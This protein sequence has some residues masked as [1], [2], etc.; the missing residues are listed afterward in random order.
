MSQM[1]GVN[2]ITPGNPQLAAMAP[3]AGAIARAGR[4]GGSFVGGQ[5]GGPDRELMKEQLKAQKAMQKMELQLSSNAQTAQNRQQTF[6]QQAAAAFEADQVRQGYDFMAMARQQMSVQAKAEKDLLRSTLV[7]HIRD[8]ALVEDKDRMGTLVYEIHQAFG[9]HLAQEEEVYSRSRNTAMQGILNALRTSQEVSTRPE[10]PL[11]NTWIGGGKW[12]GDAAGAAAGA[13]GLTDNA[14]DLSSMAESVSAAWSEGRENASSINTATQAMVTHLSAA[15]SSKGDTKEA[16]LR[17]AAAQVVQLKE[18]GVTEVE[19]DGL[20]DAL[21]TAGSNYKNA[22]SEN[23]NEAEGA[24]AASGQDVGDLSALDGLSGKEVQQ[25]GAMAALSRRLKDYDKR[26]EVRTNP[27]SAVEDYG[28]GQLTDILAEW[29]MGEGTSEQVKEMMK[30]L[31]QDLQEEIFER[32]ESLRR[33][34]AVKARTASRAAGIGLDQVEEI[35]AESIAEIAEYDPETAAALQ[36]AAE[37]LLD[38]ERQG[39]TAQ[40]DAQV[41]YAN[42]LAE[43]VANIDLDLSNFQQQ[44]VDDG[45][46]DIL[47]DLR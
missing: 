36:E 46:D 8:E 1:P 47:E 42:T 7:A 25:L 24:A 19:I 37:A 16:A 11:L 2:Q 5:S 20:M 33:N 18:L 27:M 32:A 44:V 9:S 28:K 40:A 31:P 45:F 13:L 29:W 39:A 12:I 17:N 23:L 15:A 38:I 6:M 3:Q 41:D 21:E 14:L 35:T 30:G 22:L 26:A 43:G 4:T 10:H 34:A